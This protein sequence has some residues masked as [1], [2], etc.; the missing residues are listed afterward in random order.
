MDLE[1]LKHLRE[2]TV[3][4]GLDSRV[5]QKG[6]YEFLSKSSI[7]ANEIQVSWHFVHATF[8]LITFSKKSILPIGEQ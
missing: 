6:F 4:H 7:K 5:D 1:E 8:S 2:V 3:S